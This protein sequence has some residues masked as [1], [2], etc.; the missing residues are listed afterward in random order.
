MRCSIIVDGPD[1]VDLC[2]ES[3][4]TELLR[5]KFFVA[6][7]VLS[8]KSKMSSMARVQKSINGPI[9]NFDAITA[10][11]SLKDTEPVYWLGGNTG[12]MCFQSAAKASRRQWQGHFD[13]GAERNGLDA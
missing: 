5:G 4:A 2:L 3:S 6:K 1:N 8:E 9:G 11:S 7:T 10:V 13:S 12:L